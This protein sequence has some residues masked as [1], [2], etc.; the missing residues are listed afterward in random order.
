MPVC[1]RCK[2]E[3]QGDQFFS[4]KRHKSGL[5]SQCKECWSASQKVWR[6]NNKEK[7][8]VWS[9]QCE[10]NSKEKRKSQKQLYYLDNR[11]NILDRNKEWRNNNPK[12]A[13]E[14][15][16]R[17]SAKQRSSVK[18]K[19]NCCMSS[20]LRTA[21]RGNK[22]GRHWETLVKFTVD[23]LKRHLEK[24]FTSGMS[25]DNYGEAWEIDHKIP[26]A[27]FN[28]E[29]P[30]DIDFRLCWSLKNLQPLEKTKNRC[31]SSKIENPFQPSLSVGIGG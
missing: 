16:K 5:Y 27:V 14:L 22:A 1:N 26:I 10:N 24:Q 3:K 2:Q 20:N 6:S 31:K 23:Q 7:C 18:G 25:W 15:S 17:A 9:K 28:F 19:L 4:D 12:K 21:L 29:R 13:R 8:K 11:E 30:G